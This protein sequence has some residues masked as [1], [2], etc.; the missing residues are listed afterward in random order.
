MKSSDVVRNSLSIFS[1]LRKVRTLQESAS[2]AD[3]VAISMECPAIR[4][5]QISSEFVELAKLVKEQHC[6]YLLEIGTFRGG[7][8][9]VF[10]QVAA[11]SATVIS[12]DFHF[13]FQGKLCR[14][15]QE[16]FFRKFVRRGQT[17]ILV[18]NNSHKPETLASI[19]EKLQTHKLDFLFIDGDHRYEGVKEDFKMY[20]PL[21]RSGG[22]VAF[23]DI[24][25]EGPSMQ[26][27][28]F[29]EQIKGNYI[30]KEFIDKTC[31]DSMGIGVLWM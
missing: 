2:P 29:W 19:Q 5:Q 22:I 18:R 7:T 28:P 15:G 3:L 13:T 6:N 1:L 30:H 23:H 12:L 16:P 20:S 31:S 24:A 9:F 21:V 8:L 14:I 4:P 17:L 27:R 25:Q 11:A 10:S 26:V